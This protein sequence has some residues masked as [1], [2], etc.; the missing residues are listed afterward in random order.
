MSF[1]TP[2]FILSGRGSE[3]FLCT[4]LMLVTRYFLDGAVKSDQAIKEEPIDATI[5]SKTT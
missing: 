3:H 5:D 4:I 2:G 1:D